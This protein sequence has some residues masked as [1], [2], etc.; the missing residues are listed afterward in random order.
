MNLLPSI[1]DILKNSDNINNNELYYY[2]D[3][4]KKQTNSELNKMVADDL[5]F[6]LNIFLHNDFNEFKENQLKLN[7]KWGLLLRKSLRLIN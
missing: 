7:K 5:F 2:Q 1:Y 3:I 6:P 4:K